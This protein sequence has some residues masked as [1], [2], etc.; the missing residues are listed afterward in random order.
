MAKGNDMGNLNKA[1]SLAS[2][3]GWHLEDGYNKW[4]CGG[5]MAVGQDGGGERQI[6]ADTSCGGGGGRLGQTLRHK[7]SMN[8]YVQ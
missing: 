3:G 4:R 6:V 1:T 2:N 8:R 7:Q 5:S